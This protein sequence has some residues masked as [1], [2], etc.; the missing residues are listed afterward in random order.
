MHG[1]ITI[2]RWMECIVQRVRARQP[3]YQVSMSG[4]TL[5]GF[6]LLAFVYVFNGHAWEY[7]TRIEA[8]SLLGPSPQDFFN[9]PIRPAEDWRERDARPGRSALRLPRQS[10]TRLVLVV[11]PIR[12]HGH[13]FTDHSNTFVH[14][15]LMNHSFYSHIF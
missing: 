3:L 13:R 11:T 6:R 2:P 10:G 5:G 12:I 9:I 14:A 15:V 8:Y 1:F 4:L 7:C